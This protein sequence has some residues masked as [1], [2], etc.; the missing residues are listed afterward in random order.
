VPDKLELAEA[1]AEVERMGLK[2]RDILRRVEK[3]HIFTH[4][5]WN[6]DGVYMELKE[7]A[8]DFVWMDAVRINAEAALP[9]A[10]R[11]FWEE[12]QYV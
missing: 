12:T 4:V 9:T 7:K 10:F 1:I 6:M 11:Q 8:G 5:Q 3:K 2:P